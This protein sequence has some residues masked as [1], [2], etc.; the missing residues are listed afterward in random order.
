MR[1][2]WR[3]SCCPSLLPVACW[4]HNQEEEVRSQTR[5][6]SLSPDRWYPTLV[7]HD[8]WFQA[9][10]TLVPGSCLMVLRPPEYVSPSLPCSPL[11]ILSSHKPAGPDST[12]AAASQTQGC[13]FS[14]QPQN[15]KK[16]DMGTDVSLFVEKYSGFESSAS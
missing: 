1:N 5:S 15:T 8:I 4:S 16:T 11:F 3:V 12:L 10:V 13:C 9:E 14:A 6:W 2:V 7:M